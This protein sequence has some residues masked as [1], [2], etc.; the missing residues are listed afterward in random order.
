[1]SWALYEVPDLKPTTRLVLAILADHAGH[2]GTGAFP[3]MTTVGKAV[4]ID[5]RNVAPHLKELE[6]RGIIRRGDQ[7]HVQ[8]IPNQYR[9]V[10]YDLCIEPEARLSAVMQ[11]SRLGVTPASRLGVMKNGSRCDA[12][13]DAS[14]TQ[15]IKPKEN[16]T[17][18]VCTGC[19]RMRPPRLLTASGL[20]ADCINVGSPEHA[21]QVEAGVQYRLELAN[22]RRA[23]R[24]LPP[25]E[26]LEEA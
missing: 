15:T 16:L 13:G 1:M 24:G 23:K 14:I 18:A 19:D 3:S 25:V 10:V 9:P 2:D 7:R 8:H 22:R 4:G 11:T 6:S 20:C 17:S 21:A 5:R 12:S 26:S